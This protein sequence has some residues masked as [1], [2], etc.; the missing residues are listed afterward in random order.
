MAKSLEQ[1]VFDPARCRIELAAFKKFDSHAVE[2][3]TFD[4]LYNHLNMCLG[5]YPEG[6]KLET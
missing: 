3:L 2:C 6:S 1:I 4:D 5:F